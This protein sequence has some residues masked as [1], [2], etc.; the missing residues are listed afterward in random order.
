MERV[1]RQ[2]CTKEFREQVVQLVQEQE[3]TI[4][5]AASRLA[6]SD[7]TLAKWVFRA[8]R[9]QMAELGESRRPVTDLEEEMSPLKL[10]LAE[11]RMERDILKGHRVLCEGAAAR[12][13]LMMTV[14]PQ[15]PMRLLCRVLEVSRSG[16]YDWQHRRPS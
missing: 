13:A 2:K 15:Y 7:N 4:P 14:R 1:P 5:E 11:V 8:Q 16:Y 10:E 12:Y 3:L 6:M 9:G